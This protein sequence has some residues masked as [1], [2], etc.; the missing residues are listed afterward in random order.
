MLP[1]LESC[2]YICFEHLG[3]YVGWLSFHLFQYE[4]SFWS[5]EKFWFQVHRFVFYNYYS[6]LVQILYF[7][8]VTILN[9][10]IKS[11]SWILCLQKF[12]LKLDLHDDKDKQKALKTVA[13]L[14]GTKSLFCYSSLWVVL[15]PLNSYNLAFYD[16][17]LQKW[18]SG[19]VLQVWYTGILIFLSNILQYKTIQF[20]MLKLRE[21]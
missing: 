14:S 20:W 18:I 15:L 4:Q 5:A 16:H 3:L 17:H 8:S 19:S 21:Y 10:A 11:G 9:P 2:F 6:G 1:S 13:T 7:F 12:V